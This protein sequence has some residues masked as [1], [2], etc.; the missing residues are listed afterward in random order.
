MG[1]P[2]KATKIPACCGVFLTASQRAEG[3]LRN[4]CLYKV[5]KTQGFFQEGGAG[6]V[7]GVEPTTPCPG[8]GEISFRGAASAAPTPQQRP[9]P[10]PAFDHCSSPFSGLSSTSPP[11]L[12]SPPSYS[13]GFSLLG[14]GFLPG[15]SPPQALPSGRS[16]PCTASLVLRAQPLLPPV[17]QTFTK[18]Q[19]GSVLTDKAA[20]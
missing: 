9:P 14:H 16:P 10:S 11:C 18:G 15:P 12:A 1:S 6:R 8:R 17:Q 7:T 2:W 20:L 4:D 3:G 13:L 5:G 19:P